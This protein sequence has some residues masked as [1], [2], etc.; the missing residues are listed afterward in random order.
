[1]FQQFKTFL[2]YKRGILFWGAIAKG[3][4]LARGLLCGGYCPEAFCRKLLSQNHQ[5]QCFFPILINNVKKYAFEDK[6]QLTILCS[7]Q[8]QHLCLLKLLIYLTVF[9][10]SQWRTLF[11]RLGPVT[12]QLFSYL[13]LNIKNSSESVTAL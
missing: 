2:Q 5:F 10:L 4:P 6:F 1:M 7:K 3:G 11:I 9:G 13:Q 12:L 8:G